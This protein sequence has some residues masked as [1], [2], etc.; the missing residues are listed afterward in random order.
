MF[1]LNTRAAPTTVNEQ[2]ACWPND[3]GPRPLARGVVE[4]KQRGAYYTAAPVAGYLVRWALRSAR[5]TVLE[6]CFGGG[7]FLQAAIDQLLYLG[8]KAQSVTGIE[9]DAR[10]FRATH[11]ALGL[12]ER[13]PGQLLHA[14]FFEVDHRRLGPFTTVVGNPPFIRYQRFNGDQRARALARAAAQGVTL[15]GLT[16]A[17]APFIV[18]AA[19]F[20]APAGRLA[21]VAP[22]ELCH[23]GYARPVLRFLRERFRRVRILTFGRKLFSTLNEDTVLVLADGYGVAGHDLRLVSLPDM[24]ALA[25]EELSDGDLAPIGTPTDPTETERLTIYLLPP[26]ARELYQE[27]SR[28][29]LTL[30]LGTVA[31][32]GIGY[33]TG[34]NRFFHLSVDGARRWRLPDHTLRRAVCRASWLLGLRLT[35]DDLDD[36]DRRGLP[37]RLLDLS[38]QREPT[39]SIKIY[40]RLGHRQGVHRAY[41]CRVRAPWYVVPGVIA[42]DLFLSYMANDRPSLVLNEARAIA[43]NTLLC[44]RVLDNAAVSSEALAASWWT[45]LAAM[46]AEVE[47]HSLG[48][49]MLK[50]EPGE[51]VNLRLPIPPSL[52]ERGRARAL[53]GELDS[54]IRGGAHA[55]ALDIGDRRILQE[56]LG[57][58]RR[59][60]AQLRQGFHLLSQRRRRR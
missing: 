12:E 40:L 25:A 47:G 17:W 38:Q 50:L 13:S 4:Q 24:S 16:S 41:K 48:G 20:L 51:A 55:E 28:S 46:S 14:D 32:A 59:D 42:P 34:N 6:P 37:T 23:A 1:R 60:C 30:R 8:G 45:S 15:T 19:S 3:P 52:H 22:A 11:E 10:T 26:A 39:D 57:L 7:V 29:S 21:M 53:V 54:L 33:V 36:L 5:D 35:P 31:S 18:H 9:A 49:G 58:S 44:V 27:L 2:L 43:P 56:G